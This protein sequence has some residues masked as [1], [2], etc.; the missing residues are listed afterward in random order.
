MRLIK[1]I[2]SLAQ[3]LDNIGLRKEA[4][5]LDDVAGF[6]LKKSHDEDDEQED[7]ALVG[8]FEDLLWQ[9]MEYLMEK[10]GLTKEEALVQAVKDIQRLREEDFGDVT[11][12]EK[13]KARN[14]MY[15][16]QLPYFSST[17]GAESSDN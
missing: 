3:H 15:K 16:H 9:N 7:E 13:E 6:I 10:K 1:E 11:E 17:Q 12:E 5:T 2:C 14:L 4:D 8:L